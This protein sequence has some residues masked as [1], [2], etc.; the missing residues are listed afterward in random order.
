MTVEQLITVLCQ[1]PPGRR[2]VVPGQEWG[3]SEIGDV[4]SRRLTFS[5][6]WDP[7]MGC[8]ISHLLHR[9]DMRREQCVVLAARPSA[10]IR[11]RLRDFGERDVRSVRAAVPSPPVA[12]E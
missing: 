1:F 6:A 10:T 2:V 5:P 8:W 12:L 4:A 3:L 9:A 11:P 7:E